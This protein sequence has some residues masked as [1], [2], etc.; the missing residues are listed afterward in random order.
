MT[1]SDLRLFLKRHEL[2]SEQFARLM[3]VTPMAVHH[4]LTGKRE[5]SLTMARLCSLFDRYPEMKREFVS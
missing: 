4:W 3:G 2:T 5:M 1:A